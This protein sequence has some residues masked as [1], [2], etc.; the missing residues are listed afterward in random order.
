MWVFRNAIALVGRTCGPSRGHGLEGRLW[1]FVIPLR[2]LF[3]PAG[4]LCWSWAC[5]ATDLFGWPHSQLAA[6][7]GQS[8][9]RAAAASDWP[10]V[11]EEAAQGFKR[12]A[13]RKLVARVIASADMTGTRGALGLDPSLSVC[14][15]LTVVRWKLACAAAPRWVLLAVLLRRCRQVGVV[16][17]AASAFSCP[18]ARRGTELAG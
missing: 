1:D 2:W 11:C 5:L 15:G 13:S 17:G 9:E 4:P 8:S 12:A 7:W 6:G 16:L 3:V 10:P 18:A 14:G